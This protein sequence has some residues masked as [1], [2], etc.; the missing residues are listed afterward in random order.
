M[1]SCDLIL[2]DGNWMF[3]FNY[4]KVEKNEGANKKWAK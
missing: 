1:F 4:L 3:F 2:C